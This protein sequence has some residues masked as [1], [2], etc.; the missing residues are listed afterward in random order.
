MPK[1]IE[2]EKKMWISV[3]CFIFAFN[4]HNHSMYNI[5]H[6]AK[7]RYLKRASLFGHKTTTMTWWK[8]RHSEKKI[9]VNFD[10]SY[11][12][13]IKERKIQQKKTTNNSHT[14]IALKLKSSK[15]QKKKIKNKKKTKFYE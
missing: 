1:I 9:D 6:E 10:R 11:N 13:N 2:K 4:H 14:V 3:W 5:R 8:W 15:Q 7:I 12:K